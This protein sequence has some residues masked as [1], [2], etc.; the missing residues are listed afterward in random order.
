M[1]AVLSGLILVPLATDSDSNITKVY[2]KYVFHLVLTNFADFISCPTKY[3][4][5]LSYPISL[6]YKR[7]CQ[8]VLYLLHVLVGLHDL[9]RA[10]VHGGRGAD[11]Q[12]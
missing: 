8:L 11:A 10:A 12:A 4:S 2:V 7:W 5:K 6:L 9:V 3:F 1:A